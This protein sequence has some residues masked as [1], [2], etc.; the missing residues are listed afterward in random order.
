VASGIFIGLLTTLVTVM[1]L[2]AGG[3]RSPGI[4]LFMVFTLL[5]TTSR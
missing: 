2:S 3:I 4:A 5:D 1:A